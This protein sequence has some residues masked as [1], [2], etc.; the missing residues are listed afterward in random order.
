MTNDSI[1]MAQMWIELKNMK[2]KLDNE[3]IPVTGHL[4]IG[5]QELMTAMEE[6]SQKIEKHFDKFSLKIESAKER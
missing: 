5:D 2:N 1:K 6:L 3:I 4:Q